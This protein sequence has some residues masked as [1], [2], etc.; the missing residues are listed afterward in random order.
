MTWVRAQ[1]G[2][3]IGC[4]N[5]RNICS[6]FQ[7]LINSQSFFPEIWSDHYDEEGD[8][9]Q[10]PEKEKYDSRQTLVELNA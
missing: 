5:R 8:D 2:I 6:R 3:R 10:Q 4:G 7:V 1:A 9:Q